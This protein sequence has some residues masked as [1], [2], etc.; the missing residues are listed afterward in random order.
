MTRRVGAEGKAEV[1]ICVRAE[2]SY[3]LSLS[4]SSSLSEDWYLVFYN[5]MSFKD[6]FNVCV[7]VYIYNK[8]RTKKRGN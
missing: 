1:D 8:T 2:K 7:N 3:T 4:S 6:D 5:I